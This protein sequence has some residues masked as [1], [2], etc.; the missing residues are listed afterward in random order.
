MPELQNQERDARAQEGEGNGAQGAGA[1]PKALESRDAQQAY[2]QSLREKQEGA[3]APPDVPVESPEAPAA[4]DANVPVEAGTAEPAP[5]EEPPAPEAPKVD[6]PAGPPAAPPP[7]ALKAEAA[8]A[9]DPALAPLAGLA[10]R[11]QPAKVP[12]P[13][14]AQ[15][16]EPHVQIGRIQTARATATG[17]I[18]TAITTAKAELSVAVETR[19][20]AI[21]Q[22]I[23][24]AVAETRAGFEQER[25]TSAQH[26][27]TL[28][29]NVSAHYDAQI[30]AAATKGDTAK[31]GLDGRV[32]QEQQAV[33]TVVQTRTAEA[34]KQ[35]EEVAVTAVARIQQQA[36][37]ARDLGAQKAAS[38]PG[39]E[40]GRKQGN[41]AK[42]VAES[43]AKDIEG[44]AP[45]VVGAI[46]DVG[47]G[48]P[49]KFTE[50]GTEADGKLLELKP[51]L[52]EQI[53]AIVASAQTALRD[54]LTQTNAEI[55]RAETDLGAQLDQQEETA[56]AH[57]E[58]VGAQTE[59]QLD[60]GHAAAGSELD[61]SA[62]S[63]EAR[64]DG[65]VAE[66]E[67]ML[68]SGQVDPASFGD[69]MVAFLSGTAEDTVAAIGEATAAVEGELDKLVGA[70][71]EGLT[72]QSQS[73]GEGLG[74]FQKARE[75]AVAA[76]EQAAI[77]GADATLAALDE[78]LGGASSELE[79]PLVQVT[80]DLDAE[81]VKLLGEQRTKID[82]GAAEGLK[83]ND[84][85]LTHVAP[86]MKEAADEAAWAHDHPIL[87]GLAAIGSFI[88]GVLVGVLIIALAVVVVIVALKAAVALLV[89]AGVTLVVAKI[90]VAVVAI[91]AVLYIL[92]KTF[93]A[94]LDSGK[95]PIMAA[96]H[97][98]GDFTGIGDIVR[99]FT[100]EG[101]TPF[102]R[103]MFLGQ[104]VA[105]IVSFFFAGRLDKAITGKLPKTIQ[106]PSLITRGSLWNR[107]RKGGGAPPPAAGGAAPV[108]GGG[109]ATVAD[110]LA[111]VADDGVRV[112]D[113]A[114]AK[115]GDDAAR[116]ADD[117][118]DDAAKAETVAD[119]AAR[120]DKVVDD[121]A[122]TTDDAAKAEQA[123]GKGG[124]NKDPLEMTLDELLADPKAQQRL[125]AKAKAALDDV[126]GTLDDIAAKHEGTEAMSSLKRSNL[127]EFIASV[128][129]KVNR[130]GYDNVGKMGDMVRGRIEADTD[131]A[132]RA[133]LDDIK[134]A[135]PEAKIDLKPDSPYPRVHI[136]LKTKNGVLFEL[137][138]GTK[139]TTR[140]LETPGVKLPPRLAQKVGKTPVD[141][142][143]AKYD[144]LDKVAPELRAKWGLDD[145][146][147][148]YDDALKKTGSGEFDEAATRQIIKRIE[149]TL[150][151]MEKEDGDA[152]LALYTKGN[153]SADDVV[154]AIGEN[155]KSNPLRQAYEGEVAG[156]RAKVSQMEAAGS[157]P[158]EIARALHQARRDLGVK[159]KDLT[160]KPLKDFIYHVNTGRY[161]DPLGPS[162]DSLMAKYGGDYAKIIDASTRPNPNVDALLAK[163]K[164]WLVSQPDRYVEDAVKLM[165]TKPTA[166][167]R[168][169]DFTAV[170]DAK[171]AGTA[172][173]N[174]MKKVANAGMKRATP[175]SG[176]TENQT[177]GP[178]DEDGG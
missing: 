46:E 80:T 60:Q 135:F 57:L 56:V 137:Q 28:R 136:D 151:R 177:G 81:L 70:L 148:A 126:G 168:L 157:T 90:I 145:L 65:T 8:P 58:Q 156:L 99:C 146:A 130:K 51:Q 149:E 75:E 172:T 35:P 77:D 160:P 12:P 107:F 94:H 20:M 158:E 101:A 152:L 141:F 120:A 15:A 86:K 118:V 97:T 143:V 55:D 169:V 63:V 10:S 91:G 140:F 53:D 42:G 2:I 173:K 109:G 103:G 163:F 131:D 17:T 102:E 142:H 43:V 5:K 4:P 176:P 62:L 59:T 93:I 78:Q 127:D 178:A 38:Y 174:V 7:A 111:K 104:G 108:A 37:A 67:T 82:E 119:D 167:Q 71:D 88:A 31:Q 68:S 98:A 87:A 33:A 159:Y 3:D 14:D 32:T 89:A 39:T 129:E 50:M 64:L 52:M 105:T 150:M 21:Q 48:A 117:V 11:V 73:R 85:A 6:G 83:K 25:Q 23:A 132:V 18:A 115:V 147:T 1:D 175:T 171:A 16:V 122:K 138:V 124:S 26:F 113:D 36:Q 19:R 30:A 153:A 144:V 133:I 9:P 96:L 61:A 24:T 41:A 106:D 40:R 74:A 166:Y 154:R 44:R 134:A 34:K 29:Q 95:S 125:H 162:F 123:A 164:D 49:E 66:A 112:A 45:E 139:A 47:S 121:A 155:I 27:A 69:Q 116:V 79:A 54:S 72:A 13:E 114:A 165:Q 92:G 84:E 161:G 110:D 22:R 76:L 100:A 128:Q 170:V